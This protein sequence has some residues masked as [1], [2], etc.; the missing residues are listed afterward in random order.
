MKKIFLRFGLVILCAL[1]LGLNTL[2][3]KNVDITGQVINAKER[4]PLP[5]AN[6]VSAKQHIG[7][8]SDKSGNFKLSNIAEDDTLIISY[9]GFQEQYIALS[10]IDLN[11]P[12]IIN[13]DYKFVPCQTI[14]VEAQKDEDRTATSAYSIITKSELAKQIV[15][16]DVPQI[17]SN[18][19]SALFYSESGNSVG[20]TYLSIRGFDQRRLSISVNGVPQNDP[21]DHNVYWVDF[22]NIMENAELIQVQR[23]SGNGIIGYPAIGG[24]VNIITSRFSDKPKNELSFTAAS[25]NTRKYDAVFSSGL[26]ND[27]YSVY[28][29]LSNTKTDGYRDKAYGDYTSY[30]VSAVRFDKNLT[31]Q[32]NLYGGIIKDGLAYTGLPKDFMKNRTARKANYSYWDWESE[33]Q[34]VSEYSVRR[35]NDEG[36]GFTQPHFELLN[37]WQ[38]NDKLKFNSTLFLVLGEG[39]FDYDGSW[40]IY[41]D[42][43]FRLKQNGYANANPT[44]AL[45]RA[46]VENRQ[47]GWSGRFSWEHKNGT[48]FA[49]AEIRNHHSYHWGNIQYAEGIPVGISQEYKYYEYRG[50]VN[51]LNFF[52]HEK[53]NITE[54]LTGLAELQIANSAYKLYDEKYVETDFT[55]NHNFFNPKVGLNY[56]LNETTNTFVSFARVSKEPRLKSYYDAAESSGGEKPNF[57][58]V[59]GKYD[60]SKPLINP[61]TMN[62]LEV[63]L[64]FDNKRF[65]LNANY[66]LMVFQNEIVKQ[67]QL[68]RF[69][70]PITGNVPNSMH[71][72]GELTAKVLL[73]KY[74]DILLN[75]NYNKNYIT[76]GKSFLKYKDSTLVLDMKGN[77]ISGCPEILANAALNFKYRDVFLSADLKYVG[78]FYSNNYGDKFEKITKDHPGL[79]SYSDNVIDPSFTTNVLA[80]WDAKNI[81]GLERI[82]LFV[83]VNNIFDN[84]YAAYA[85]GNEF[86]FADVRNFAVGCVIGF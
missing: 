48:L 25:H 1:S 63:G 84:L 6:I 37:E 54:S 58:I 14:L 46:Y 10:G 55:I 32:I 11:K 59:D 34:N 29:K 26:I 49:G 62:D 80:G 19:P 35:R 21:E 40:S 36:E 33:K 76:E 30:F 64:I 83:Q 57:E 44:N 68:D 2:T 86:F 85:I 31:S 65:S 73:N 71:T 51:A 28:A 45:I 9:I 50:G 82:K 13:M 3:A 81:L 22:P 18:T 70:Q 7:A 52:I 60:F 41:S 42:D 72:G 15:M 66:Y 77:Q 47:W 20:Y 5:L 43:Y 67:G 16:Q 12:L 79:F 61:E 78:K 39:Y 74:F 56:K 4:T 8:I 24:T 38:I 23:G 17:L 75:A 69:G 27:K 53:Y